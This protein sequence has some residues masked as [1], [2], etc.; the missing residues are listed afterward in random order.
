MFR[1]TFYRRV[2]GPAALGILALGLIGC[3]RD[4][5]HAKEPGSGWQD[6]YG[7]QTEPSERGASSGSVPVQNSGRF[8]K[9]PTPTLDTQR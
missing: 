9:S 3:G 1:R 6:S 5:F 4:D 7:P 8:D 2:I